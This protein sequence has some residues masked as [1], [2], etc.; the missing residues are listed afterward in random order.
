MKANAE[1]RLLSSLVWIDSGVVLSQNRLESFFF[2]EIK[3]NG[4]TSFVEFMH[5]VVWHLLQENKHEYLSWL[6]QPVA[7][8]HSA[9]CNN[10]DTDT[11]GRPLCPALCTPC[12]FAFTSRSDERTQ[13]RD[14]TVQSHFTST[15]KSV[16]FK[17]IHRISTPYK[18][19]T[20]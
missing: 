6:K 17:L 11:K 1:P 20:E 19:P 13:K 5:S 14:H 16:A 18:R 2:H 7:H 9:E 8:W 15:Q 12:T 3:C 10:T 4:M